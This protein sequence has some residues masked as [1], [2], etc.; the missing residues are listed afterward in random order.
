MI[1]NFR[2]PA[3]L[4]N[5]HLQSML[6]SLKLRRRFLKR[7]ASR[8]LANAVSRV[9]DCG[10]GARLQGYYSAHKDNPRD[11]AVLIHGWEGSSDSV[12]LLSAAN[13]L[14]RAG[15][16]I[17]RLN[18]RDHGPTHHLNRGLFHANRI[19]EVV[20][21]IGQIQERFR[22][23]RLLLGGFSLGGNFAL[24]AAV[25]APSAGIRLDRAVAICPVLNPLRTMAVLENSPGYHWY[26]LKKW[27]RSLRKKRE[28]FPNLPDLEDL[29]RLK[30]LGQTTAFFVPRFT[31]FPDSTSYLN[32]Y[33][34]IGN[35]L[36]GLEVPSHIIASRDD[37]VIPAD[38]L[39]RLAKSD[40]LEVNMPTFGGHC[41]FIENWRLQSR[42]NREMARLF[43]LSS[44]PATVQSRDR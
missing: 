3:L 40:C 34:I 29:C 32:G 20:G 15:F 41:G 9:L 19:D 22:H 7:R 21:A 5:R 1:S 33:A 25:R 2:P 8:M 18:L 14:W 16:D 42:A 39:S 43:S 6:A 31:P 4:R 38:D 23:E 11:L 13:H 37:P 44:Q 24:R 10:G 12:Y 26:F 28:I 30:T 35:A 27:R 36:S 17:F